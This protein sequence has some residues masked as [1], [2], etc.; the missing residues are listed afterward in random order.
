MPSKQQY[1]IDEENSA[2]RI[3][4]GEAVIINAETTFYYGLNVSATLIWQTLLE[5]DFSARQIA[6]RIAPVYSTTPDEVISGIET[7]LEQLAEAQM[8]KIR[9]ADGTPAAL[10]GGTTAHVV[11]SEREWMEPK[12]TQYDTLEDLIACGE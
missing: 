11:E 7:F 2:W 6:Q 12:L 10:E 1:S 9:E 3:V 4:D 5:E 8:V